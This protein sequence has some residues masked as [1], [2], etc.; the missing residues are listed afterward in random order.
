MKKIKYLF[1]LL[2]PVLL[3]S[4]MGINKT[5]YVND[6]V[7]TKVELSGNNFQVVKMVTGEVTAKY[8]FGIGGLSQKNLKSNAI[9][10]MYKNADL[11]GRQT[12]VN[13]T[14]ATSSK[15]ILGALVVVR[16]ATAYGYVIEYGSAVDAKEK[17]KPVEKV[18]ENATMTDAEQQEILKI[19]ATTKKQK[20]DKQLNLKAYKSCDLTICFLPKTLKRKKAD[21]VPDMKACTNAFY[22]K[23]NNCMGSRQ[24]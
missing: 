19:W 13:I 7:Q 17:V 8:V 14:V 16:T 20:R 22:E 5:R 3:S 6:P 15:N 12:V 10:E 9:A 11:Q 21:F 24:L 4:C 2:I 18:I 23:F 1:W